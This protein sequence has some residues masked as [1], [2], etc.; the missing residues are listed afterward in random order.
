MLGSEEEYCAVVNNSYSAG[1]FEPIYIPIRDPRRRGEGGRSKGRTKRSERKVGL[2]GK[3]RKT[4][5]V[6]VHVDVDPRNRNLFGTH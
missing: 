5:L 4:R 6:G 1:S 2:G 3:I